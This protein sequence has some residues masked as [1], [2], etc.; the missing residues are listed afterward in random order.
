MDSTVDGSWPRQLFGPLTRCPYPRLVTGD[1]ARWNPHTTFREL[2]ERAPVQRV[3]LPGEL[4]VW[5]VTGAVQARQA[6]A[7]AR[8]V[9]DMRRLPDPR[10]GF[11]G[12]RY[13]DDIFAVEGRHLLNS[14]GADHQRLRAVLTPLFSQ[15]ASLRWKP[16]IEQTC[17]HL[18]DGMAASD[19][20]DLIADYARP[21]ATRVTAAML[22]IA[23]EYSPRLSALTLSL[24]NA[25]DPDHPQVR[26]DRVEVFRLW[27][28]IIGEKRRS[29]GDDVLTHLVRA[30]QRGDL[31][32]QEL[33][34]VAWGLYS[35]GISPA[36]TLIAV[37]AMELMRAPELRAALCEEASAADLTEELLRLASPFTVAT[38]R[39]ALDEVTIGD[40][41]IPQGA[42]VLVS[43]AAANRDPQVF[44]DP[45]AVRPGRDRAAAHLAFGLRPHY[46]PGAPLARL[47]G[48]IALTALF[49]TFPGLRLAVA[50][51]ELRWHGVLVERC[52]DSVPVY[53]TSG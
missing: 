3:V 20:A 23:T 12:R 47:Q 15:A 14:D 22:G 30:H 46:C 49:T 38:W 32:A 1:P 24:I 11:G 48:T 8:L 44:P 40:T 33:T 5:L 25:R 31:S 9:H 4:V 17:A 27:A 41:V 45:D 52:Y 19:E 35:G 10:Q 51:A 21:L 16:F 36:T 7:E 6:L 18:L 42:V 2:R 13:P 26:Q 43:V 34:S 28:R 50:E 39:F 29:P 53:T 37:G